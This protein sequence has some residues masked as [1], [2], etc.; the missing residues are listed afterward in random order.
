LRPASLLAA[1]VLAAAV[2]V[3][4]GAAEGDVVL[5]A[6]AEQKSVKLGEDAVLLLT[7]TNRTANAAKVPLLRLARD[8]ISVRVAAPGG[9]GGVVTRLYGSFLEGEGGGLEFRPAPSPQRKLDP[10]ASV[11]ARIV[12]PALIAGDLAFTAVL[13]DGGASPISA[14]PVVVEVQGRQR[15][16]AQVDTT[17]GSFRIDLDPA[18]A[19]SS[20]ANFWTLANE[21]FYDNLPFHRVVLGALAQ[22]GDPRGTGTGGPGWYVPAEPRVGA[23]ARGDVGLAHGAHADSAGS[24]WFVVADAKGVLSGGYVRLG[25]VTE[26]LDT[27]DQLA[28]NATDPKT[29]R[30]KSPDRVVTVRTGLR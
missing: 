11:Q 18:G 23:A 30:P 10:G 28:A 13:G 2:A 20:V 12:V 6:A 1:I 9:G 29:D 25:V 21:H 17:K 15:V 14:K 27:L 24:Q 5:D 7:L 22:T 3:R 26:G 4:A 8:S 19:Y 16:A